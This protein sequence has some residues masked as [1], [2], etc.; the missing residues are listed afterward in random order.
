M[1]QIMRTEPLFPSHAIEFRELDDTSRNLIRALNV[2][3]SFLVQSPAFFVRGERVLI[4]AT[5]PSAP[6]AVMAV[7]SAIGEQDVRQETCSVDTLNP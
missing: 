3:W 2:A 1:A 5:P 7:Y 4:F 6:T